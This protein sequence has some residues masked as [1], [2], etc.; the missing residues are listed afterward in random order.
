[1]GTTVTYNGVRLTN[2]QTEMFD[3]EAVYDESDTDLLYH[4][5]RMAWVGIVH[6]DQLA[7]QVVTAG[8]SATATDSQTRVRALLMSPRGALSVQV[9]GSTL[10]A[11][12]PTGKSGS[13]DVNNGPKPRDCK[14]T[15][16]AGSQ[17][18][19]IRWEVEVCLVECVSGRVSAGAV[20][21]NRWSMED[22]FDQNFFCRRTISGRLRIASGNGANPHLFRGLVMPPLERHFRWETGR[23]LATTNGLE[24]EYQ[25]VHQQVP[26]SCP[27]PAT[28]WSG[29]HTESNSGSQFPI[30][31]VQIHVEGPPTVSKSTLLRLA[32]Q[33]AQAKI[34]VRNLASIIELFAITNNLGE[35]SVDVVLR[36]KRMTALEAD[37]ILWGALAEDL[38]KPLELKD[39]PYDATVSVAPPRDGSFAGTLAGLFVAYLQDP[40]SANHAFPSTGSAPTKPGKSEKGDKG[41]K[42]EYATTGAL[43]T[44]AN[45]YSSAQFE[46]IYTHY[47]IGGEYLIDH[48]RCQ[49]PIA[50]SAVGPRPTQTSAL[51]T[52]ALP[53]AQRV[54]TI[55]AERADKWPTIHAPKD[56]VDEA[57][58]RAVLLSHRILPQP[59]KLA[60]DGQQ[61]LYAVDAEFVY[62]LERAPDER[63]ALRTGALPYAKFTAGENLMPAD[64]YADPANS[65]KAVS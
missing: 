32:I 42:L 64:V 44:E 10:L 51:I 50:G 31:E 23:F 52:L 33:V 4:R 65:Q 19:R 61:K 24:L 48:H 49:C 35:N 53:T 20:L 29:S 63:A 26:E 34:P 38:L 7:R 28:T 59:P 15:H 47:Q 14:I 46:A 21:N 45:S 60:P 37:G 58:G 56:Y 8:A 25:L 43:P 2:V 40:C 22:D 17:V 6:T 16:I 39:F 36:A 3:Q 5:F 9:G 55:A 11:A 18:L 30:S 13:L 41:P 62:A 12:S 57:G 27:A 1:M 54:I